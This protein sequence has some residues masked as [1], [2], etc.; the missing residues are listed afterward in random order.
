[1]I[2]ATGL[3]SAQRDFSG[4]D[5]GRLYFT[6]ISGEMT[7][8]QPTMTLVRT[9][10]RST[11]PSLPPILTVDALPTTFVLYPAHPNP[12]NPRTSIS[13]Y[14]PRESDTSLR[15]YDLLGRIVYTLVSKRIDAGY[16]TVTWNGIDDD[17]RPVGSGVYLVE[18]RAQQWRQ[19]QKITLLK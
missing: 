13:F 3:A 7:K 11:M 8:I 18:M 1:L 5:L 2:L 4:T 10:N 12:F 14:A 17:G 9:T 19:I 16:H 15:V 6:R